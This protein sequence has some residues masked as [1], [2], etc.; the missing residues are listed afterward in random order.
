MWWMTWDPWREAQRLQDRMGRLFSGISTSNLAYPRSPGI[1]I[2]ASEDNAIVTTEIPGIDPKDIDISV[3]GNRVTI[4]GFRTSEQL[5]NEITWHRRE[6]AYG[7]FIRTIHLPFNADN[8]GVE[9][10]YEKGI[11]RITLPRAD[12]DKP[13]KISVKMAD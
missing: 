7:N 5:G 9:A 3:M 11:L 8:N 4:K 1:T 2:W 6:R 10:K 13:K 12:M